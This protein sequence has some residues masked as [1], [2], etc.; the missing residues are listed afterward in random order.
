MR[1]VLYDVAWQKLR[2]S[3]LRSYQPS[4]LGGWTTVA[5]T[6]DNLNRLDDYIFADPNTTSVEEADMQ[7]A[8]RVYRGLNLLNAT[9][10]G[11]VGQGLLN[12]A[13]DN[14]VRKY[15]NSLQALHGSLMPYL[16]AVNDTWDWDRVAEDLAYLWKEE[17]YWFWAIHNDLVKRKKAT[18]KRRETMQT[19]PELDK[20]IELMDALRPI[21]K[22]EV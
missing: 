17:R 16:E 8:A 12:S 3:F 10:M 20:F 22:E 21:D 11:Y 2:V 9:R 19:R 4:E 7:L 5:G 14:E 15:R 6:N 18:L 1:Q 13:Q